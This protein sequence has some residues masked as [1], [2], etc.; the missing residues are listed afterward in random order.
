[1]QTPEPHDQ[2]HT[3]TP[4]PPET[5]LRVIAICCGTG[6]VLGMPFA[7]SAGA[8]FFLPLTAAMVIAIA[9]V[10][11]LEWL[12]RRG[13]PSTL[14][15][16]TCVVAMLLLINGALAL[17]IVPASDWFIRL[18]E[19]LPR[20]RENLS[21][22]IDFYATLQR[23]VDESLQA[24]ATNT[25][26]QAQAVAVETPDSLMG[27]LSTSAPAAAIQ[28]FFAIL[29]VFFFLAGWTRLRR[30]T[31]RSRGSFD[32]AMHTARIIQ[33]V[34]DATSAY[35]STIT[36]INVLLGAAVALLLWV[37]GMPSPLMWG[38]IVALCNF[39][40]YVGPIIAAG[41]LAMGGLMSFDSVPLAMLPAMLQIGLHTVEANLVTPLILGR[42][43]TIN[44]LLILVSLSLWGWIWGAPGAFL[45]V[46][47]LIIV[48]TVI[49]SLRQEN[50]RPPLGAP[51]HAG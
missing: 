31:I 48:Q 19:R 50:G 27:Y 15:A 28:T 10:P 47:L 29:L 9:L 24:F 13:M 20:I 22:L 41:L 30:T 8:E 14:A 45:A 2:H 44:P 46:P 25:A 40:P 11:A 16:L 38:G 36:I 4:L 33:N 26:A 6:L 37:L 49:V 12:E 42:R 43:L 23:F 51:P 7:L 1:M 39:V 21:P 5:Y 17:I 3:A 32:A 34:V 18:P 35:I